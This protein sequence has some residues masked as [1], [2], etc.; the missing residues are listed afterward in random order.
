[1]S[2]SKT[3]SNPTPLTP[4][5]KPDYNA[6]GA[7]VRIDKWLWAARFFKTRSLATEMVDGGKVKCN[8]ERVKPAYGV[9][10]GDVLT[11]PVGWDDMVLV[12]KALADKRGS[13]TIAQ[14]LYE[15]T[16][17][18]AAQ[19]AQRAANRKLLKDPALEIK[20]RPTKRDRRAMDDFKWGE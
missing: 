14:G 18:S 16:P 3:P 4:N 19:R 13:A 1:M 12:V 15:E 9:Q 6:P 7:K 17:E 2:R 8:D 11:V 20:A 5:G 10:V